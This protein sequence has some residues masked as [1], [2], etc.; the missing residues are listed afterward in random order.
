MGKTRWNKNQPQNT[1]TISTN[2]NPKKKTQMQLLGV[3][4][5]KNISRNSHTNNHQ[6]A[7]MKSELVSFIQDFACL[8]LIQEDVN[9]EMQITLL[10]PDMKLLD[11]SKQLEKRQKF[12][13]RR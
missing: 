13:K 5:Q 3:I 10:L 1:P 11:K 6:S 4:H 2:I 9:G 12:Q 8:I 7:P